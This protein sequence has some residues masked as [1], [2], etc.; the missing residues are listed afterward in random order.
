M[1]KK[2]EKERRETEKPKIEFK[3]MERFGSRTKGKKE[4]NK[5]PY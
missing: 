5:N 2:I 4:V 3:E 1:K